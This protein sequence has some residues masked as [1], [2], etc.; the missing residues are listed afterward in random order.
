MKGKEG[1]HLE[2][3]ADEEEGD[4]SIEVDVE[5]V[6]PFDELFGTVGTLVTHEVVYEVPHHGGYDNSGEE[7][8]KGPLENSRSVDHKKQTK[9]DNK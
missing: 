9:R 4:E 3:A 8:E 6:E 1:R 5:R 2:N 7:S